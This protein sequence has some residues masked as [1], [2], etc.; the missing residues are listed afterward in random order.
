MAHGGKRNP[1]GNPKHPLYSTWVNMRQRCFNPRNRDYKWYGAVGIT[2]D[3]SWQDFKTFVTDMG[4]KPEPAW[5]WSIERK[6]H[7][8][9][10]SKEN[11]VW[12]NARQQQNNK[13]S[14]QKLT[15][16]GRTQNISQWAEELKIPYS[17]LWDR[18]TKQGMSLE[19]AILAEPKPYDL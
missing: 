1:N 2:V 17:R 6:D 10:Y 9:P 8:G 12:A 13:K 19:K 18:I 14:N 4:P 7:N 5:Q 16:Q 11:C 15:Y 3:P